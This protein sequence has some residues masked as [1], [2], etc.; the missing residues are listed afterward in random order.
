MKGST[1]EGRK[2]CQDAADDCEVVWIPT[3][4]RIITQFIICPRIISGIRLVLIMEMKML[5]INWD[6]PK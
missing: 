5:V 1:T 3:M 4:I 6:C 2:E